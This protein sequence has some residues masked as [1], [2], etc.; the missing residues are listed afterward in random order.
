M[1][2][3]HRG[4]PCA[5]GPTSGRHSSSGGPNT[6][7]RTDAVATFELSDNGAAT[8][9]S[10][11]FE[12]GNEEKAGSRISV[13]GYNFLGFSIGRYHGKL[14]I[15]LSKVAIQRFRNGFAPCAA[16]CGSKGGGGLRQ[17]QAHHNGFGR[18]TTG[19]WSRPGSSPALGSHLWALCCRWESWWGYLPLR[20]QEAAENIPSPNRMRDGRRSAPRGLVAMKAHYSISSVFPTGFCAVRRSTPLT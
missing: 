3:C 5:S 18:P 19:A 10:G 11:L 15:K 14:L 8:T 2:L 12:S 1:T 7:P 13:M 16:C 20:G 4:R 17:D 6:G 9:G